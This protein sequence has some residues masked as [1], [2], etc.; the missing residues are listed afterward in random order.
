MNKK[1]FKP[2]SFDII[3]LFLPDLTIRLHGRKI[4]KLLNR[5]QRTVQ[6]QLHQLEEHNI[7]TPDTVGKNREYKLK[8]DSELTIQALITAEQYKTTAFLEKNFEIEQ[9]KKILR[10]HD[11]DVAIA[12]GSRVKGYANK[13]SDLDLLV[14]GNFPKNCD[15]SI[16]KQ[17]PLE[18]HT[19]VLTKNE[20]KQAL[21]RQKLFV[22]DVNS[23]HVVLCGAE[24]YVFWRI[25]AHDK[26]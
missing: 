18:V 7:F 21:E 2:L 6:L 11:V 16:K 4:A 1:I 26:Q 19:T 22:Q 10:E 12:F 15:K 23:D 5:N 13:D 24:K 20:F 3:S 25:H 9:L 8:L 17:I 14:I